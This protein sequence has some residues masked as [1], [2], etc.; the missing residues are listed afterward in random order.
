MKTQDNNLFTAVSVAHL[1]NLSAEVKEI[2]AFDFN[3]KPAKIFSAADMWNIERRKRG[4]V[5]RRFFI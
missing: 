3:H 2:I 4:R 5:Q 1:A